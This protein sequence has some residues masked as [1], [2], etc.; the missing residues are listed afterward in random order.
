MKKIIIS[1][2]AVLAFGSSKA[3]FASNDSA[4]KEFINSPV[5]NSM[6]VPVTIL[7]KEEFRKH[8]DSFVLSGI[9]CFY[10][11]LD[12]S[13]NLM[14]QT[15]INEALPQEKRIGTVRYIFEDKQSGIIHKIVIEGDDS[16]LKD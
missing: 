6:A 5:K 9:Q 4:F 7:N 13:G 14:G 11:R 16:I 8:L 12:S 2:L 3:Q 10:Q 1:A 15:I